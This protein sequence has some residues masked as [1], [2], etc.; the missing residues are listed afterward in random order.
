MLKKK[1]FN[2]IKKNLI[3]PDEKTRIQTLPPFGTEI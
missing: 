2:C 3:S 1:T